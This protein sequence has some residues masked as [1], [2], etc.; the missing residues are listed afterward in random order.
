MGN[1]DKSQMYFEIER[2]LIN[3]RGWRVSL[4]YFY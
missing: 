3:L 1:V 4:F 2:K